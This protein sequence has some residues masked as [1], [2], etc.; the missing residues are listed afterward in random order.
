M[1]TPTYDLIDS[2]TLASS[3]SSVTFSSITQ[4]YRDLI[5]VVDIIAPTAS[6]RAELRFNNDT[7]FNYS[8]M[9]MK[10]QGTSASGSREASRSSIEALD[11]T[12]LNGEPGRLGYQIMDYSSTN[13]HKTVLGLGGPALDN[14]S[15]CSGRWANTSAITEIDVRTSYNSFPASSTFYL[16]GIAG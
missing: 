12:A 5:V 15:A 16:Y 10:G 13:K 4:A 3:A 1:A 7:G 6:V 9:S 14:I 8:I 2:I 11:W